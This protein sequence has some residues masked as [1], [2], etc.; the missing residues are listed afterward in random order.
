MSRHCRDTVTEF[1]MAVDKALQAYELVRKN[2]SNL[3]YH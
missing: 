1:K 2:Y 3:F